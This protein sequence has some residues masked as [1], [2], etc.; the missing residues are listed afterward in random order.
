MKMSAICLFVELPRTFVSVKTSKMFYVPI[1]TKLTASTAFHALE[2][3]FRTCLVEDASRGINDD[4]IGDT[5]SRIME[6]NGCVI[7]SKEVFY[8]WRVDFFVSLIPGESYGS[9]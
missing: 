7:N 4:S 8:L 1:S 3:G 2:L 9:R 6:E 5:F